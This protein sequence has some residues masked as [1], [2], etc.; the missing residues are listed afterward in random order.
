[1]VEQYPEPQFREQHEQV[2]ISAGELYIQEMKKK[3]AQATEAEN[4]IFD[5][6]LQ[7]PDVYLFDFNR[8][9]LEKPW[10]EST[11]KNDEYFNYGFTE[12]SFTC[13]Q[14]K[15]LAHN[16]AHM[17]ELVANKQFED[18]VLND[19]NQ[20]SHPKINFYLPH[21]F[22]GAGQPLKDDLYGYFNVYHSDMDLAIIKPGWTTK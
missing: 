14:R 16:E 6:K 3:A 18:R 17:Q 2:K 21:E 10:L 20:K 5:G 1:M 13:Y 22:G 15:V 12:A 19:K 4:Q 9:G 8:P 11:E 7:V